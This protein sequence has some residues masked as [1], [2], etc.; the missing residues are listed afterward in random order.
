LQESPEEAL[1]GCG[2][3]LCQRMMILHISHSIS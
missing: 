2:A 3:A 1:L